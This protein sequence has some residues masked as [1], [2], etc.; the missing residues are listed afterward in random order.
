MAAS[1]RVCGKGAGR[2]R[3][4]SAMM[5][6]SRSRTTAPR[7]VRVA[8]ASAQDESSFVKCEEMERSIRNMLGSCLSD[9]TLRDGVKR[10]VSPHDEKG[11]CLE[12]R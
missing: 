6:S 4:A 3:A 5:A 2:S 8:A 10:A 9:T 7:R 12:P 1:T 11:L